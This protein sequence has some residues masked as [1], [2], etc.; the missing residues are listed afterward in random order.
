MTKAKRKNAD[1]T[2]RKRKIG[3]TKLAPATATKIEISSVKLHLKDPFSNVAQDSPESEKTWKFYL[4]NLRHYSYKVQLQA[5]TNIQ[6]TLVEGLDAPVDSLESYELLSAISSHFVHENSSIRRKAGAIFR[7]LCQSD[8]CNAPIFATLVQSLIRTALSDANSSIRLDGVFLLDSWLHFTL[9][10]LC[11][12]RHNE[13]LQCFCSNAPTLLSLLLVHSI[14]FAE[15][16]TWAT[17][18]CLNLLLGVN[19]LEIL[20]L[21]R[22]GEL[23]RI[24]SSRFCADRSI[25]EVQTPIHEQRKLSNSVRNITWY[26][27]LLRCYSHAS[28][29]LMIEESFNKS[30]SKR[31]ISIWDALLESCSSVFL[32]LDSTASKARTALT[33]QALLIRRSNAG[34][35]SHSTN[36]ESFSI[37]F[38]NTHLFEWNLQQCDLQTH[39]IEVWDLLLMFLYVHIIAFPS[40]RSHDSDGALTCSTIFCQKLCDLCDRCDGILIVSKILRYCE[41]RVLSVFRE[42]DVRHSELPFGQ[43]ELML[44]VMIPKI[45]IKVASA[46]DISNIESTYVSASVDESLMH[47]ISAVCHSS[48]NILRNFIVRFCVPPFCA[49]SGNE[50]EGERCLINASAYAMKKSLK[51]SESLFCSPKLLGNN[52]TFAEIFE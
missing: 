48:L 46:V 44:Y 8:G 13:A 2:S 1:F 40:P 12:S 28:R 34:H 20:A 11:S 33:F 37:T 22:I 26:E 18:R 4:V 42:W 32:I 45:L 38:Y 50:P 36:D 16:G 6:R 9:D 41:E 47:T 52:N 7:F 29:L 5:L 21:E 23:L 51:E 3:K 10:P 39:N 14:G 30:L 35:N 43:Y 15:K 49:Y 25:Q 17:L 24:L 19:R 31:A 27:L